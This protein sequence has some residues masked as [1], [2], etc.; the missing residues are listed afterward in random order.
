MRDWAEL[1]ITRLDVKIEDYDEWQAATA[2][3]TLVKERGTIGTTNPTFTD[4]I[5]AAYQ[6]GLRDGAR[7]WKRR[8]RNATV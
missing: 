6:N 5:T 8:R 1:K 4:E 3:E 2:L 7:G